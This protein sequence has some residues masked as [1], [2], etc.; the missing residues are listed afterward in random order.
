VVPGEFSWCFEEGEPIHA[1]LKTT[2]LT[3]PPKNSP[4]I[5]NVEIPDPDTDGLPW[6]PYY[7][8]L[9]SQPNKNLPQVITNSYGDVE[10]VSEY[11]DWSSSQFQGPR[12]ANAQFITQNV[13]YTYAVLSCNLI[14]LLGLRGISVLVASGDIGVGSACVA[15]DN[16][17]L[18]FY[19][20]F[21]PTCP[22]ITSVGGTIQVSPESAWSSS[23][24]GFSKYFPRPSWQNATIAEYM[25][26]VS[27]ETRE[28]YAQYTDWEGRG[29][30]DI[31]AHSLA[32]YFPL[33]CLG[34]SFST[35]GTSASSPVWAGVVA[36]LNDARLR[37]G[38]PVLGWLNPLLYLAGGGEVLTDITDGASNG[39]NRDAPGWGVIEGAAWNATAGWDPVTGFGTPDFQKL[40]EFVMKI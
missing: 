24:G 26:M 32:P 5:P 40:L 33:I 1:R 31:A 17:T 4:F 38:K 14:G 15:P 36:L 11:T 28:Y 29:F 39:C 25:T 13:P 6:I 9:L 19:P 22:Y 10:D 27:A 35:G 12:L 21:P 30:P 34:G 3:V 16:T 20:I 37:A 18:E 8:Y 2:R 23:S 7:R